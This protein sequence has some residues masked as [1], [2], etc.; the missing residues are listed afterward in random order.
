MS[1]AGPVVALIVALPVG[2]PGSAWRLASQPAGALLALFGLRIV[3]A[4]GFR[5]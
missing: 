4:A 2:G 5:K 1:R 3:A